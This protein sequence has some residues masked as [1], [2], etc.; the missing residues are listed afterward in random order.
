VL[1]LL[2]NKNFG[3]KSSV[4]ARALYI[5]VYASEGAVLF[6]NSHGSNVNM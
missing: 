6:L 1:S 5:V 4:P 3:G 2:L